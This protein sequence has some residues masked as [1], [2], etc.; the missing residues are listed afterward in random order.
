MNDDNQGSV[1]YELLTW[2]NDLIVKFSKN[3]TPKLFVA[4]N[5]SCVE[6]L[7]S[8]LIYKGLIKTPIALS[9]DNEIK[10]VYFVIK[11]ILR[12]D[13]RKAHE[14]KLIEFR[15]Y[16]SDNRT[17]KNLFEISRAF[18]QGKVQKLIITDE[19]NIFGKIDK[20]HGGLSIH[21]FDLDHE[22]DDILDDLA[23]MVL[24]QGGEVVIASIDEIPNGRPILAILDDDGVELEKLKFSSCNL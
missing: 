13:S 20:N 18:F 4:A 19:L 2:L 10:D 6:F 16:E 17:I 24:S 5:A 1:K 22:D 12:E 7:S 23:Q 14:K 3:Q 11:Q 8:N 9:F 21:P 15:I